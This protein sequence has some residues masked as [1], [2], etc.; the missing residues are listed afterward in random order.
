MSVA[1]LILFVCVCLTLV[2]VCVIY[3]ACI[4][5]LVGDQHAACHHVC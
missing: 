1:S 4:E 5:N 3:I 2:M